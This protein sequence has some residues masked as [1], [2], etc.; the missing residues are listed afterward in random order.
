MN[1]RQI[2]TNAIPYLRSVAIDSAQRYYSNTVMTGEIRAFTQ[3]CAIRS[4]VNW[5]FER[6]G[7]DYA[8]WARPQTLGV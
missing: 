6:N 4:P 5:G 7:D 1:R 8:N 2:A 3:A